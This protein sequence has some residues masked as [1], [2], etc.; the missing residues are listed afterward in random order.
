MKIL[1][2]IQKEKTN[3]NKVFLIKEGIF[4]RAY[5]VSAMLFINNI[6]KFSLLKR[7][8]KKIANNIVFIGFP[9]SS[10]DSILK[11]VVEK[12]YKIDTRS[13][14]L[15]E[16]AGF[17]EITNFNELKSEFVIKKDEKDLNLANCSDKIKIIIN[18]VINYPV[19]TQT[20][21]ETMNFVAEIQKEL[22]VYE[23]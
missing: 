1:E 20:P 9:N 15:I 5:E 7:Y 17:N 22:K 21:V 10:L 2:I 6:K 18:K 14:K 23:L 3:V 12:G 19:A 13:E 11:I 8:I 4:W 16:L